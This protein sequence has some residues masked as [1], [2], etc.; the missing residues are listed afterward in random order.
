MKLSKLTI[1]AFAAALLACGAWTS[2]NADQ[3]AFR[4]FRDPDDLSFVV[5]SIGDSTDHGNFIEAQ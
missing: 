1:N 5:D 3:A 2:V 4:D